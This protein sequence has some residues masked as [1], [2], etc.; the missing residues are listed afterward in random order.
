MLMGIS[1][2]NRTRL[3]QPLCSSEPCP[4]QPHMQCDGSYRPEPRKRQGRP[5]DIRM[6]LLHVKGVVSRTRSPAHRGVSTAREL[7]P[8]TDHHHTPLPTVE[9]ATP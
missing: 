1:N 6:E 8:H 9:A 3:F 2:I 7:L 5:E 4:Q